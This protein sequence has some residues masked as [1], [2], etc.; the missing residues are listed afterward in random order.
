MR[1]TVVGH[2]GS[3]E[4]YM[5]PI[6]TRVAAAERWWQGHRLTGRGRQR[7]LT[8]GRIHLMFTTTTTPPTTRYVP[9]VFIMSII[10]YF[11]H[12]TSH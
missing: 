1:G 4:D 6:V 2:G 10:T 12:C 8:V 11:P 9:L 3:Y 7:S 5:N